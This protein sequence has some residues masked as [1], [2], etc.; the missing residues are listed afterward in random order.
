MKKVLILLLI[1]FIGIL[2][3]TGC[4][5]ENKENGEKENKSKAENYN[6]VYEKDQIKLY[7]A[8]IDEKKLAYYLVD[9]SQEDTLVSGT[10]DYKNNF[11]IEEQFDE[12]IKLTLDGENVVV[13][14]NMED[15]SSG[16]Y[17]RVESYDLDK[18]YGKCYG[19]NEYYGN[20]Y[21]G[22]FTNEEGEVYIYQADQNNFNIISDIGEYYVIAED[23]ELNDKGDVVFNIIDSYYTITIDGD[24]LIYKKVDKKAGNYE[25]TFTKSASLTKK[26]I[27]NK[28]NSDC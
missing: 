23:A 21:T 7:V 22:K 18:H 3:L 17:K 27:I 11:V 14:T 24:Q 9:E 28:F 1:S 2:G 20:K 15:I 6:G 25:G 8:A 16:T 4:N 5:E 19:S 13:E 12:S 26:D 10:L